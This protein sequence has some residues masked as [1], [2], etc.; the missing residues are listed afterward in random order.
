[1]LSYR[2]P[3]GRTK[4]ASAVG[5]AAPGYS[6]VDFRSVLCG[7]VGAAVVAVVAAGGFVVACDGLK[8]RRTGGS[9]V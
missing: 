3:V 1:V 4:C 8:T 6:R 9:E 7:A 2:E 5:A